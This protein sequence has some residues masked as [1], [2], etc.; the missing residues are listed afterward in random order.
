M[1]E[2]IVLR[3]PFNGGIWTVPPESTVEFVEA[4][5]RAGFERVEP[6]PEF[7]RRQRRK[8]EPAE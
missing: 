7:A 1:T 8:D 3:S 5:V 6:K 2:P 4:M